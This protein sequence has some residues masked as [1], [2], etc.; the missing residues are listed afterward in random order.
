MAIA[1]SHLEQI[2]TQAS[3]LSERLNTRLFNLDPA[4]VSEKQPSNELIDRWC[5]VVAQG[6][7][8][9]YKK[10]L[11]WD[12]LD[13]EMVRS[14]L[15]ALPVVATPMPTWAIT[16][17]EIIT[18]ASLQDANGQDPANIPVEPENPLPFEDVLL[19]AVF[20]ARE[21]LLTRLESKSLPLELLSETA[22]LSLEHSL[23]QKLTNL[24]ARTLEYEFSHS[25]PL[26]H[27]LL[28]LLLGSTQGTASTDHYSA[29]VQKLL[30]DGLLTF[31][32]KYPVLGR[33]IATAIDFW[34]EATGEFL[35][36]L[37]ADLSEIQQVFYQELKE[38][39][40]NPQLLKVVEINTTLSDPHNKGRSV[41][42]LTFESGLKLI[43]KPK[44]LGIEVAYNQ[45]LEWCNQHD[46]PLNFKV[47]KVSDRATYGWVEYVEQQPCEDEAAAERF[48]QRAGMLLCLLYTLGTTDCHYENLIANGEHLVLIDMETLMHHEANLMEDSPEE[49]AA[50]TAVNQQFWDS[51]LRTGMLPR[52]DF[53]KDNRIA[54]DVS[55]LGSVDPQQA[56]RRV[57]RWKS[58]NT[59]DMRLASETMTIALQKNVPL[60]N[61]VPL[62]PNDYL[63]RLVEGFGQMYRF[64][65]EQRSL[66]LADD[67]PLTAFQGQQVRFV[68]RATQVYGVV[69]QKTLAP[70][71]LRNGIARSIEL[72]IL[73][74]AFLTAQDQP[75]AWPICAS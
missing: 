54:Y 5:F 29:F 12:G 26:G 64:L 73:S 70:E 63:D 14:A 71:F 68:F 58:V 51:V 23:L 75:Y 32:Q 39:V 38:V 35:Q 53:N 20:V 61:K 3:F 7:W 6:N 11:Q 36:R 10:R 45:L 37:K 9:K 74:R 69:L 47:L 28:S 44:N 34:V 18:T 48:Y 55:G 22:Y 25:R 24:C 59:D 33:L 27:S 50:K 4:E 65:I 43:Y 21:K 2:V 49:T 60:L 57:N 72:D 66:L 31:F 40:P 67:S 13:I 56:P 15:S 46:A 52:W 30:Q 8:E 17:S 42:A 19:P 41:I 16:L 1:P 62:S